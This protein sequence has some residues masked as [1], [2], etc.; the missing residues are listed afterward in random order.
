[1]K[2]AQ[3]ASQ[4]PGCLRPRRIMRD[5]QGGTLLETALT[6]SILLSLVF[7][8]IEVG[9][10]LYTYHFV[11]YAAREATRFAIVRGSTCSGFSSACPA[12][13]SDIQNYVSNLGFPGIDIST[14]D[15]SVAWASY[16]PATAT[17]STCSNCNL[18]GDQVQVTVSYPFPFSVPFV[19]PSSLQLSSTS[20][21][22]ISQ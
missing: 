19:P 3:S 10:M 8:A 7:G 18:P 16:S 14:S 9:L 6:I 20:A 4:T 11:S 13:A 5:E 15:V 1:M 2:P 21:M 12:Q 22:V 17:W